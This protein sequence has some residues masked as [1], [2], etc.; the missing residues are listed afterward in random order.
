MK[1]PKYYIGLALVSW[2]VLS[3]QAQASTNARDVQAIV[4]S[5]KYV[6]GLH[7]KN[8]AL[9]V[10]ALYNPAIPGS[11]SD[12][13]QF[14]THLAESSPT[15]DGMELQG[16]LVPIAQLNQLPEGTVIFVSNM[17]ADFAEVKKAAAQHHF[18][19]LGRG[20]ECVQSAGCILAVDTNGSIN[21]YL[22]EKALQASGFDVDAA[23][24]FMVKPI[25]GEAQ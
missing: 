15:K 21:I 9:T 22:N 12:A 13:E 2:L 24:K 6:H 3:A 7:K 1:H 8:E 23:F 19:T 4:N 17:P 11:Q 18:F 25:Q 20:M 10:A 16:K 5:L 14:L